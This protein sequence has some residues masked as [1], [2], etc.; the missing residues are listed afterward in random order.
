[1]ASIEKAPYEISLWG[2]KKVY[3]IDGQKRYTVTGENSKD[4]LFDDNY[5]ELI[6]NEINKG[7]DN[8]DWGKAFKLAG[9]RDRKIADGL[10]TDPRWNVPRSSIRYVFY[11]WYWQLPNVN[12]RIDSS[13]LQEDDYYRTYWSKFEVVIPKEGEEE[14]GQIRMIKN[15]NPNV[16]YLPAIYKS[17]NML[18]YYNWYTTGYDY[19]K[20]DN[21]IFQNGGY[22]NEI[23]KEINRK[24]VDWT[25]IFTYAGYRDKKIANKWSGLYN[26]DNK[27]YD[28]LPRSSIRFVTYLYHIQTR[29]EVNWQA[30]YWNQ[31][32]IVEY[33]KGIISYTNNYNINTEETNHNYLN[34]DANLDNISTYNEAY[35]TAYSNYSEGADDAART[36]YLTLIFDEIAAG[37]VVNW[38]VVFKLAG[39]RDKKIAS[40]S[41][42]GQPSLAKFN[43]PRSTIHYVCYYWYQENV[44]LITALDEEDIWE[45][46]LATFSI[47]DKQ[48]GEI[49]TNNGYNAHYF[50]YSPN[51]VQTPP[52]LEKSWYEIGYS[53]SLVQNQYLEEQKLAVIG[54]DEMDSPIRAF[55]PALTE[56]LNGSHTLTFQMFYR[57]WDE[58]T[59]SYKENPFLRYMVNE[60][61]VKLFRAD[62]VR[63]INWEYIFRLAGY[64]D[65]KI[66]KDWLDYEKNLTLVVYA[67][68]RSSIRF[69]TYIWYE[70]TYGRITKDDPY[71][72]DYWQYFKIVNRRTGQIEAFYEN[73]DES[74]ILEK[75]PKLYRE[76]YTEAYEKEV[77]KDDAFT[78][79]YMRK[80]LDLSPQ[81]TDDDGWL[82]FVIKQIDEDTRTYTNTYTCKDLFVNELGK[83]G[84]DIELDDELQNSMGTV[85]ELGDNILEGSDWHVDRE[86]SDIISQTNKESLYRYVLPIPI[87]A[88]CMKSFR[89]R[90]KNYEKGD[91]LSLAA[92][93]TIYVFYSCY[94]NREQELQFYYLNDNDL[95]YRTDSD[96]FI[97][98]SPN[99]KTAIDALALFY[100]K[101]PEI[102][103]YMGEKLLTHQLS[104]YIPEIGETCYLYE[105]EGANIALE[106]N[107]FKEI[108]EELVKSPINWNK[109]FK[110]AGKRDKK[111]V[112]KNVDVSYRVRRATIRYVFRKWYEANI[113]SNITSNDK[114]W[115]YWET[116]EIISDETGEIRL[117]EGQNPEENFI[118]FEYVGITPYDY[119][120]EGYALTSERYYCYETLKYPTNV[121]IQNYIT[122]NVNFSSLDGWS[123]VGDTI[124]ELGST[125]ITTTANPNNAL[126]VGCLSVTS[127]GYGAICNS[128]L[129]DNRAM[130]SENGLV[131]GTEFISAIKYN[132]RGSSTLEAIDARIGRV[133]DNF[134]VK[135]DE[136]GKLQT[137]LVSIFDFTELTENEIPKDLEGYVVFKGECN[138]SI[139]YNDLLENY[140]ILNFYIIINGQLDIIDTKFFPF[141]S[142]PDDD[143]I[144]DSNYMQRIWS[145][146][147]VNYNTNWQLIFRI[148]GKRDK[149]IASGK[150]TNKE[151]NIP[152]SSLRYV[153][154]HWYTANN[155]G[156]I[157]DSN[158]GEFILN[159]TADIPD[160]DDYLSYWSKF[161]ILDDSKGKI[162]FLS[163]N[164]EEEPVPNAYLLNAYYSSYYLDE[165]NSEGTIIIPDT[166]DS[167]R[168][169]YNFFE[170]HSDETI[171]EDN[172]IQSLKDAY[173]DGFEELQNVFSS[174]G[175]KHLIEEDILTKSDSTE[176]S[177]IVFKNCTYSNSCE[178]KALTGGRVGIKL[179]LPK[180]I[181]SGSSSSASLS[182]LAGKYITIGNS[183]NVYH[184][185]SAD[186]NGDRTSDYTW[187]IYNAK[188]VSAHM[189]FGQ[190]ELYNEGSL[191]DTIHNN[192]YNKDLGSLSNIWGS[193]P[194]SKEEVLKLGTS[195]IGQDYMS[196]INEDLSEYNEDPDKGGLFKRYKEVINPA[197][198]PLIMGIRDRKIADGGVK[199]PRWNIPRSSARFL[200]YDFLTPHI[201]SYWEKFSVVD[202]DSAQITMVS[203]VNAESDYLHDDLNTAYKDLYNYGYNFWINLFEKAGKRD[204]KLEYIRNGGYNTRTSYDTLNYVF[205]EWYLATGQ[206]GSVSNISPDL[207][208]KT[209]YNFFPD[210]YDLSKVT[211]LQDLQLTL[212][213][214]TT[215]GFIPLYDTD[216]QKVTSVTGSKSNRFNLIQD[217]CESFECW[218]KFRIN[219]GNKG[220]IGHYYQILESPSDVI[221]GGRYYFNASGNTDLTNDCAFSIVENPVAADYYLYYKRLYDKTVVFKEYIGQENF[222][223]FRY[224]VNLDSIQRKNISDQ[225]A[226][227]VIIQP[228]ANEFAPNGSCSIQQAKLNPTGENFIYNFN[229]Y[230]NQG[231]L[232]KEEIFE[233]LYGINNG[234]GLYPRLKE[235]NTLATNYID[236]MATM[237]DGLTK[238]ESQQQVYNA[239]L[240][241]AEKE[242]NKITL[243]L[244]TIK[245]DIDD[246]EQGGKYVEDL[247]T[248]RELLTNKIN[249]NKGL[250]EKNKS[251]LTQYQKEYQQ[252]SDNLDDI[253]QSKRILINDFQN[254]YYPYI[255]E[256]TWTSEDYYDPD[257][258]YDAAN[259]VL[260]TSCFPQVSYTI[261]V[262]ELSQAEGYSSYK[263]KIGDKTYV[264]DTEY[265][266]WDNKGK[267]YQ[268]EIVVSQVQSYL[269]DPSKN[270][271]TVQNYKTQFQDLFQRIAA[272]SQTLQYNEGVYSRAVGVIN[273]EGSINSKLLEESLKNNELIVSNARNQSVTW[274]EDG[275]TI[276]NFVNPNEIVR[277][278]SLGIAVSVDG[279]KNWTTGITGQGINADVITTGRL[280][281]NL[282]RIFNEN[283]PTFTWDSNGINAFAFNDTGKVEYGK[284][285]R[286]NQYGLF[287]YQA[288]PEDSQE[289]PL[290]WIPTGVDEVI[291]KAIFSLT[292]KGL[293]INLP[294]IENGEPVLRIGDSGEPVFEIKSNGDVNIRG[295][296]RIQQY[297]GT[298]YI[299][300]LKVINDLDSQIEPDAIR[301]NFLA[302]VKSEDYNNFGIGE[303]ET[304]KLDY[305][306][307][308][309]NN[310][311]YLQI[312]GAA[313]DNAKS[314]GFINKH[315]VGSG[316][317]AYVDYTKFYTTCNNVGMERKYNNG[318]TVSATFD[319]SPFN[320]ITSV[321]LEQLSGGTWIANT[322][323]KR[324]F[325]FA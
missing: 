318:T 166:I 43:I 141:M 269:D 202:E 98:N 12:A 240:A 124:L 251:T 296:L 204:A 135:L 293:S 268:E 219:H 195:E 64:R 76:V 163:E 70:Y 254:K 170:Y 313:A 96:S 308:E 271:L 290:D 25:K 131:A 14:T 2:D 307:T 234:I 74:Y 157:Y 46:Y 35:T 226:S 110:L 262:L 73:E 92:G 123:A 284:F 126:K 72:E 19:K 210:D 215:N 305:H 227:K 22:M 71:W 41:L 3:I 302:I 106:R 133:E 13:F 143:I 9:Y 1:M 197:E 257:L 306:Y 300:V 61:K 325:A 40:G 297:N 66:H 283:E 266:G 97:I 188:L 45:D 145:E 104:Q 294:V 155:Y 279:G 112:G 289:Y 49:K 134:N 164:P 150:V 42:N 119:Y 142:K 224:G 37:G 205:N 78:T 282:I 86:A 56:D 265:F 55:N 186:I 229:Y 91:K 278:T 256:G 21:F 17:V 69:V 277:L 196:L 228:N 88:T 127:N 298:E 132:A 281:T 79:N 237:I 241:E 8:A 100:D 168:V 165:Y 194:I 111:I 115:S 54:T 191:P 246:I 23:V 189:T 310:D 208:I 316:S 4:Y 33:P 303:R 32:K 178:Y 244:N 248:Q 83:T 176:N 239:L 273:L 117:A 171:P 5:M 114:Y 161:E 103:I 51:G 190:Y 77:E 291:E 24:P 263:F 261:N 187:Y 60:R 258:Y 206:W 259:S 27:I 200:C 175:T 207:K 169:P 159:K 130:F 314:I 118:P 317:S 321:S 201:G 211:S 122:N 93:E 280:D 105:Q 38:P 324:I 160:T 286:F 249:Y 47:V 144:T 10:V 116:F 48:T 179:G 260:Y 81:A 136:N 139:S 52:S 320:V 16:N 137:G 57:F 82:D 173:E 184:I 30:A 218:A 185:P 95:P 101:E 67:K 247:V 209:V 198:K 75:L 129:Y 253:L 65:W 138:R 174:F 199:D 222:A 120:L 232:N 172:Y 304:D 167:L 221:E 225:I 140:P 15:S 20:E 243:E 230:I 299:D 231:L 151:Y 252:I 236:A 309:G 90:N 292:W 128:G 18:P 63:K 156:N 272:T 182:Q 276:S 29:G 319:W 158:T 267:P 99:Y 31:F 28:E 238:L 203:G 323:S 107:Y 34:N 102:S 36:N 87:D 84:Y 50:P 154:F 89:Y 270:T 152:R 301:L 80:I 322:T 212:S 68:E 180:T 183:S 275:I 44:Q 255:Q 213:Q 94:S 39:L 149:K 59:Q 274:G 311:V 192:Q 146:L 250:S 26:L 312:N 125:D 181:W 285:V 147:K 113:N 235:W 264:E 11:F 295:N 6:Q 162:R 177:Y 62:E 108:K 242:K 58:T 288:R 214:Q 7:R 109:V 233:D 85:F 148:A 53:S 315:L 220:Q 245:H 287:G 216:Y 153:F 223:G 193:L 121:D 217:C